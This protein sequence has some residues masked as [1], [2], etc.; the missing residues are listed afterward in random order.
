MHT[1]VP[2]KD[3]SCSGRR[4]VSR[5]SHRTRPR[6]VAR[7]R[8]L[9][10]RQKAMTLSICSPPHMSTQSPRERALR[11]AVR[12]ELCDLRQVT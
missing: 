9:Q 11:G 1:Q 12:E 10:E 5:T 7:A 4:E 8:P 3:T 6:K 2:A